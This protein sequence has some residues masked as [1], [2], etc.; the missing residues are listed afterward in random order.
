[1]RYSRWGLVAVSL[2]L[3]WSA[4]AAD[5][6]GPKR[7]KAAIAGFLDVPK[8]SVDVRR[9]AN[10]LA[11]TIGKEALVAQRTSDPLLMI[12]PSSIKLTLEVADGT[13]RLYGNPNPAAIN[14]YRASSVRKSVSSSVNAEDFAFQATVPQSLAGESH[15]DMEMKGVEAQQSSESTATDITVGRWY[16]SLYTSEVNP[17]KDWIQAGLLVKDFERNQQFADSPSRGLSVGEL[18]ANLSFNGNLGPLRSDLRSGLS[19]SKAL[20]RVPQ[21]RLDNVLDDSQNMEFSVK[22]SDVNDRDRQL[23]FS[24][25]ELSFKIEKS[26]GG[27][28]KFALGSN[29]PR[30][31]GEPVARLLEPFLP[32]YVWCSG[33]V[34]SED[35]SP[36]V[37]GAMRFIAERLG[38]MPSAAKA[39]SH[40]DLL[41]IPQFTLS[42]YNKQ[43]KIDA[44]GVLNLNLADYSVVG[45]QLRVVVHSQVAE[46]NAIFGRNASGAGEAPRVPAF[47]ESFISHATPEPGGGFAWNI[48]FSEGELTF[49]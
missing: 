21:R 22:A 32:D 24:A 7:I 1:M 38:G 29:S 36:V 48:I 20:Y 34:D 49:H 35:V 43:F 3:T 12:L 30:L 10:A 19:L 27:G 8:S 9:S 4:S 16:M 17:T 33:R 23:S 37:N 31:A 41:D 44:T 2:C 5:D 25:D 15:I 14:P 13:W 18:H 6:I 40:A 42:G 11:I 45:G 28:T 26:Q 47:L 46:M 39:A